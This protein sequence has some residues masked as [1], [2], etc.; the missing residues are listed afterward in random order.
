MTLHFYKLFLQLLLQFSLDGMQKVMFIQHMVQS[1]MMLLPTYHGGRHDSFS[2]PSVQMLQICILEC[3]FLCCRHTRVTE[4]TLSWLTSK[5]F[6]IYSLALL[7]HHW[8]KTKNLYRCQWSCFFFDEGCPTTLAILRCL[9]SMRHT[10]YYSH[11]L[12]LSLPMTFIGF[13]PRA[14]RFQVQL[15]I[16]LKFK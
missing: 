12:F 7:P 15:H 11:M 4:P 14:C 3:F 10:S 16:K 2:I 9:F 13:K 6:E 1:I 8:S 5:T